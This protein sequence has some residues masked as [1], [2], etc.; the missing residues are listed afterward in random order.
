MSA[1]YDD[2]A[3]QY[4]RTKASPLG[5]WVEQP[6]FLAMAGEVHGMRVLDL[7]CGDGFYSR[8]LRSAGARAVVGVDVSPAMIAL[9]RQAETDAPLGIDY[10]CADAAALPELGQF[11]LVVAAYLLHYAPDVEALAAMCCGIARCLADG[12]RFVSLNENPAVPREE[13]GAYV[14]YGF[15]KTLA[16]PAVDGAPI[17]YRMLAGRTSFGFEVHYYSRDTYAAL[18]A[19]AGL[20]EVS[21]SPLTLD[22]A[23]AEAL[24]ADYFAAYLS[25]P[26]VI[27]LSCRR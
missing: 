15:T 8:L 21:W 16:G 22:P 3:A 13:D 14:Q 1:Q 11:D 18:L 19:A 17:R 23:G 20:R 2:I 27:G 25:R 10:L 24:G 12:A 26:P 7:A 4:V 6:S 5:K 9:A